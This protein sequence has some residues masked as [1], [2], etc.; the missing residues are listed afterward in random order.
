MRSVA[1]A[2]CLGVLFSNISASSAEADPS[3]S[4][5]PEICNSVTIAG[6]EVAC[7]T[8]GVGAFSAKLWIP[9]QSL[10]DFK[11]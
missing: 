9:F 2:I 8:E 11:I 5:K 4:P 3:V 10:W 7:L 6:I 1:L